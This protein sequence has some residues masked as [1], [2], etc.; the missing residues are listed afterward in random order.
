MLTS[1][2]ITI[3]GG[4]GGWHADSLLRCCQQRGLKGTVINWHELGS[5]VLDTATRFYPIELEQASAVIVRGMPSGTLE[6]VITRMDMLGQLEAT[7]RRILNRPTALE[8]AIDKYLTVARLAA[9]DLPVPRTAVVQS[10]GELRR[11]AE[12]CG[13]TAVIKPLFGS[14]GN[15]LS[16]FSVTADDLPKPLTT[17]GVALAQQPISHDGW[18]VR[19]LLVGDK[20]FAMKRVA[21]PNEWRTNIALGGQPRPFPAPDDWVDLARRAATAVGAELAGVDLLPG[22]DGSVWLLEVNAVPGWRALQ[23]VTETDITAAVIDL[24]AGGCEL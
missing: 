5:E 12:A 4:H 24:V 11:F 2:A 19:I 3:L 23:S 13:G 20:S 22:R 15:G 7:G 18:D 21:A 6:Q 16:T 1:P 14:N 9:A 10:A 8:V 17:T